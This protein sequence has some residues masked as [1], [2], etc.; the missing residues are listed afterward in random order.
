[1]TPMQHADEAEPKRHQRSHED[2]FKVG[3]VQRRLA[4]LFSQTGR[5]KRYQ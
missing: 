3:A 1:M 4:V 5:E 2:D